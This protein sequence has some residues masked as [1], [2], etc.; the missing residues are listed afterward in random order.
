MTDKTI[1]DATG[2]GPS[3]FHRWRRG[4]GRELPELEKVIAFCEG[5]GVSVSGAMTALGI[6]PG[7]DNPAPSAP[8]PPEVRRIMRLLADPNVSDRDKLFLQ[9]TLKMLADRLDRGGQ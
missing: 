5:L 4:E 3:T 9:E 7:R 6:S 2:V 8:M 1:A